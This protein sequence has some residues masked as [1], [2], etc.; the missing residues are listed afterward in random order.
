MMKGEGTRG[1]E[2]QW[3]AVPQFAGSRHSIPG[4]HLQ[5]FADQEA[6]GKTEQPTDHKLRK[7]KEEEGQVPKSQDVTSAATLLLPAIALLFLAPRM[8]RTTMEMVTFFLSRAAELDT[9]DRLIA[10]VFFSYM[11]R[12]TIPILIVAMV[13][14]FAFNI[15]QVGPLFVTKPIIPNFGKIIPKFGEFVKR[16]FSIEGVFNFAKSLVKMLLIGGVAY[17]FIR[18]DF[19]RLINLQRAGLWLGL[20]MVANIA[21]RLIIVCSLL[22]IV[23][24]IPDFIFQRWR[25]KDKHKMAKHEIKEEMKTYEGDPQVKHRIKSRFRELLKQ[26]VAVTV[27]RADVV[28]TNPTHYAVALEYQ[29]GA[30]SPMLTAKGSDHLAAQI[31]RLATEHGVP[32]VENKPLARALYAE[33]DVGSFVPREY[34]SVVAAV[35]KKVYHI[36]ERRKKASVAAGSAGADSDSQ[37]HEDA[38]P[39]EAAEG[40]IA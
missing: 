17:A 20:T 11:A 21:I 16:I 14:A 35:L 29:V 5:W 33:V 34:F 37:E 19:H 4:I 23:L 40:R 30:I 26:N 6:E 8:L 2:E 36:N 3:S 27:P 39:D 15:V 31:R 7:L 12:L 38:Y 24:S 9:Q 32:I 25:F 13:S 18:H 22:L 10:G 28:I 1:T